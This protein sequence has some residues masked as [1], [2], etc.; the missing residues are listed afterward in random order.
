MLVRLLEY[1]D[2]RGF[3]LLA[4]TNEAIRREQHSQDRKSVWAQTSQH[5]EEQDPTAQDDNINSRMRNVLLHHMLNY[6]LSYDLNEPAFHFSNTTKKLPIERPDLCTTLYRPIRQDAE[7][8]TRPGPIPQPPGEPSDPDDT[9]RQEGLLGP[10]GQKLRVSWRWRDKGDGIARQPGWMRSHQTKPRNGSFWFDVTWQGQ[11]GVESLERQLT[12]RG[13]FIS[14]NGTLKLPPS[15]ADVVRSHPDLATVSSI[16]DDKLLHSLSHTAHATF[17]LPSSPTFE[18]D[19]TRLQKS[20]LLM[21]TNR[22]DAEQAASPVQWDRTRLLAWHTASRSLPSGALAHCAVAYAHCMRTLLRQEGH[23]SMKTVLGGSIDLCFSQD[24]DEG[25]EQSVIDASGSH[26]VEEDIIVENGVVHIVDT[27][28]IPSSQS[29]QLNVEKTLLAMNA[30]RFVAMMRK[31]GLHHYLAIGGAQH[32]ADGRGSP[33]PEFNTLSSSSKKTWTLTV[34]ND[35][36]LENL[37][38]VNPHL[39]RLW[40][41]GEQEGSTVNASSH[42]ADILRYHIS[43]SLRFPTNLTDGDLIPTELRDW[44]LKEARQRI[45]TKITDF[46]NVHLDQPS[47]NGDVAFGEA[48]VISDPVTVQRGDRD[49]AIIYPI[50]QLLVPPDDPIQTAVSASLHLSTYVAAVFSA[51]LDR[52]LREAPGV[53]YLIPSNEAFAQLGGMAL[54]YFLANDRES[55]Q[56]LRKLVEYHAIDRI[57]YTGD[58]ESPLRPLPTLEGSDVWAGHSHQQTGLIEL[59]RANCSSTGQDQPAHVNKKDVL[60]STGVIHEVDRVQIPPD[61]DLTS[62][63]LL[64]GAKCEVFRDLLVRAGYDWVLNGTVTKPQTTHPHL[65]SGHRDHR[66]RL[67]GAPPQSYVLLAPTDEAFT[68]INLSFYLNHKQQ[69]KELVELHILPSPDVINR[70]S[71]TR[72]NDNYASAPSPRHLLLP[73]E[74]QDEMSTP[75]LLDRSRGGSSRYGRIAFRRSGMSRAQNNKRT[76]AEIRPHDDGDSESD[77]LLSDW[78]LGVLNS[79]GAPSKQLLSQHSGGSSA[80]L[81]DFGRESR[82]YSWQP[83]LK[84]GGSRPDMAMLSEACASEESSH[85]GGVFVLSSVLLPYEPNWF[86]AWGW[87]ALLVLAV[88]SLAAFTAYALW[89]LSGYK[90]GSLASYVGLAS[91]RRR[92]RAGSVGAFNHRAP[93]ESSHEALEGEEE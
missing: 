92:G 65:Q 68:R 57:A 29:L 23:F 77:N 55:R 61:L 48:S 93:N 49:V 53:T 73:L 59:R 34:P 19:L 14:L 5:L 63:K 13:L 24:V 79:R 88:L 30:T 51:Q 42:L 86:H 16:I 4:P 9:A 40:L 2:N 35:D 74:L 60:T 70:A 6:T 85:L 17:F 46:D 91:T 21:N 28:L 45:V 10:E 64:L 76:A 11:G 84:M 22:T 80:R 89:T 33:S 71:S 25:Q 81:L 12:Q 69:L 47:G 87:I 78:R 41:H 56:A 38:K 36:A 37:F 1:G 62:S 54:R 90:N 58:L 82:A 52:F 43:P 75:S 20:Y 50:S 27:L 8:P 18:N 66:G 39:G 32:F 15:L 3:T 67:L 83:A 44:R 72:R 26:I 7:M 31:A